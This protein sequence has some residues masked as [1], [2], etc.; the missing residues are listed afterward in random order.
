[1]EQEEFQEIIIRLPQLENVDLIPYEEGSR[2][3][4]DELK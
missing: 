3:R 2:A 4:K 1:M